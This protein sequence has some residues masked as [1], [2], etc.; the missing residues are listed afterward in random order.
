MP[1]RKAHAVKPA[2]DARERRGRPAV[3][4]Q[5]T[6]LHVAGEVP[7]GDREQAQRRQWHRTP[8]VPELAGQLGA[9]WRRQRPNRR[10]ERRQAENECG[11]G[12]ETHPV[13]VANASRCR[14]RPTLAS[15][16][17]R[18]EGRVSSSELAS[19]RSAAGGS[20]QL[21][22][23]GSRLPN[24]SD[25]S[26]VAAFDR[27]PLSSVDGSGSPDPAF[28]QFQL[29]ASGLTTDAP[30]G[31]VPGAFIVGSFELVESPSNCPAVDAELMGN[32]CLALT[33]MECAGVSAKRPDPKVWVREPAKEPTSVGHI[34][35]HNKGEAKVAGDRR[36][37]CEQAK[38]ASN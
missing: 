25:G 12:E 5:L 32:V 3:D 23:E 26:R 27:R 18:P 13:I 30:R 6:R 10:M 21:T 19:A 1:D 2:E 20:R 38:E 28:Q 36:N 17:F 29:L 4:D 33:T 37:P 16:L 24:S 8:G 22:T 34:A 15:A 14:P 7:V 11:Q 31:Q 35:G 9:L